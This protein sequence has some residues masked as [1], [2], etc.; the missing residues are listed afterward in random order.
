[1]VVLFGNTSFRKLEARKR[2]IVLLSSM[3]Q[4][5]RKVG[6]VVRLD[7]TIAIKT[8]QWLGN[9]L[10]VNMYGRGIIMGKIFTDQEGK[11]WESFDRF[12]FEEQI[13]ECW[14]VTTDIKTVSEY[15]LDAPLEAGRE[16]KIANMLMGIE[17]V[18]EAKFQKLFRQFEQLVREHGKT[19]DQ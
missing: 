13:M 10:I 7:Y 6:G 11:M 16:D 2:Q 15:L 12:D 1:M 19:L 3:V 18:Y 17:A 8:E 9:V 4:L 14:H 5:E